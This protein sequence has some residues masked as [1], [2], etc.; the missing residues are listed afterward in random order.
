MASSWEVPPP[1]SFRLPAIPRYS[2]C[3]PLYITAL[4]ILHLRDFLD[5]SVLRNHRAPLHLQVWT[6]STPALSCTE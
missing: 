2:L 6:Q 3:L 5:C 1:G 4:Q